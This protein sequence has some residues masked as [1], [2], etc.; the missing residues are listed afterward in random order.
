MLAT[1]VILA[2]WSKRRSSNVEVNVE[3][4]ARVEVGGDEK[5]LSSLSPPFPSIEVYWSVGSVLENWEDLNGLMNN[6]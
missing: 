5:Y 6:R 2:V 4:G 3:D 1:H